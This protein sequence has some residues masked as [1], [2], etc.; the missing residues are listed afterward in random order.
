MVPY[1]HK[2]VVFVVSRGG[3]PYKYGALKLFSSSFWRGIDPHSGSVYPHSGCL[4]YKELEGE[5]PDNHGAL[6]VVFQ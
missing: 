6:K 3:T 2:V 1:A 4:C 5:T